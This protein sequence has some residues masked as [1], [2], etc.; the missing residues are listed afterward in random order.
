MLGIYA[1]RQE[2]LVLQRIKVLGGRI[3][4]EQLRGLA[5]LARRYSG[6][7]MIH[8]TTRQDIEIRSLRRTEAA[9]P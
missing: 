9:V 2:G 7:R 3:R 4:P 5:L 1:Q 8:L 6:E